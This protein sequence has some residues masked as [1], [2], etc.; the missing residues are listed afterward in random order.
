MYGFCNCA[1]NTQP[2]IEGRLSFTCWLQYFENMTDGITECD[3]NTFSQ[4]KLFYIIHCFRNTV[5]CQER[6]AYSQKS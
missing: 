6:L 5:T 1:Q 3:F 4:Q 2:C